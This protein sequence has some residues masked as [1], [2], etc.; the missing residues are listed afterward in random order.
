MPSLLAAALTI[1]LGAAAAAAYVADELR[2]SADPFEWL[3]SLAS[4]SLRPLSWQSFDSLLAA[5]GDPPQASAQPD[6]AAA[7]LLFALGWKSSPLPSFLAVDSAALAALPAGLPI[8]R[9][10]ARLWRDTSRFAAAAA[11]TL[12]P[13]LR[14]WRRLARSAPIPNLAGLRAVIPGIRAIW[15]PNEAHTIEYWGTVW[16]LACLN[17][18]AALLA[19]RRGDTAAALARLRENVA[20]GRHLLRSPWFIEAWLGRGVLDSVVPSLRAIARQTHDER[21]A[22]ESDA[23]REALARVRADS[24]ALSR[25]WPA[26]FADLDDPVGL[27]VM[28]DSTFVPGRRADGAYTGIVVGS[29]LNPREILFGVDAR[30]TDLLHRGAAK[31]TDIPRAGDVVAKSAAPFL[32]WW[33]ANPAGVL[34]RSGL[35]VPLFSRVL[36]GLGLGNF[37]WRLALCSCVPWLWRAE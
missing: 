2:R 4:D 7:Q 26:L 5:V 31:L 15:P 35:R 24:R 30:R 8:C 19:Q 36:V 18:S 6:T 23:L 16:G 21:L 9:G 37:A 3:A 22:R 1:G 12:T 28:G 14:V 27:R 13:W 20:V 32:E 11:D 10:G 33:I 25:V 34:M 29:C 17:T